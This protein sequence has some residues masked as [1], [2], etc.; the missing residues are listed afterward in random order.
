MSKLLT[1]LIICS[2]GLVYATGLK[3][4]DYNNATVETHQ[5]S[6]EHTQDSGLSPEDQK[7]LMEQVESIRKKQEESQKLLDELEKEE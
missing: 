4:V 6:T 3:K 2:T 7:K 1:F 5:G